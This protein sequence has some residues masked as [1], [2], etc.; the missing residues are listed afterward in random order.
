[1]TNADKVAVSDVSKCGD[2]WVLQVVDQPVQQLSFDFSVTLRL[3]N[4]VVVRIEGPF[5]MSDG[6]AERL[7]NPEGDPRLLAPVLSI[8]RATMTNCLAFDDGHLELT[9]AEGVRVLVP[10]SENY[11]PWE[12]IDSHGMRVVLVPGGELAIWRS[13]A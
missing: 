7:I 8:A 9:F 10:P 11:E 13:S 4:E 5:V 1:M 2:H 12:F 3:A 6:E